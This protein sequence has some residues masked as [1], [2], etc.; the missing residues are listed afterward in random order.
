MTV[1]DFDGLLG[2][3]FQSLSVGFEDLDISAAHSVDRRIERQS[4]QLA[5]LPEQIFTFH[6][7]P[8]WHGADQ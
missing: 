6:A 1:T 8:A 4:F 7:F 2:N 3:F 5:V